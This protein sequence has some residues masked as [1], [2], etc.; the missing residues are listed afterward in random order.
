MQSIKVVTLM[1]AQRS[2]KFG[3]PVL[4]IILISVSDDASQVNPIFVE[5]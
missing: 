1:D 2:T 4:N 3:K 5:T